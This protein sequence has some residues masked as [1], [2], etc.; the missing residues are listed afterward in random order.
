VPVDRSE[1]L[2]GLPKIDDV[3]RWPEVERLDAPRWA[4]V[5]AA[6]KAVDDRRRAILAGEG[7]PPEVTAAHIGRIAA[8]LARPSLRAVVN[9]TGVVLHTNLGRAPLAGEV[10]ARVAEIAAGYSNLEYDVDGRARGSRHAH[11]RELLRELTGAEDAVVVNNNAG[12]VLLALSALATGRE[13]VVSR[14]ELIEIGGSFRIPDVMRLSGA[15]LV[16]VGTTNKTHARDYEAAIGPDTALLLKVHRSNFAIVGFTDEVGLDE[17]VALA[18]RRG[19]G[20]A[21][22]LGSGALLEAGEL[23][24]AG[25]PPEPSARAGVASGVDL[26]TF[27]GDKLLGGPQAGVLVGGRDAVEA[28]RKHPLMRALRPDKLTLA[29]LE[30]TLAIYRDGRAARDVPSV[31]MLTANAGALRR[32]AEELRR[33]VDAAGGAAAWLALGCASVS[34]PS[35]AARCR[36]PRRRRGRSRSSRATRG[37]PGATSTRSIASCAR[38][39]FRWWGASRRTGCCWTCAPLATW[40]STWWPTRSRGCRRAR[41]RARARARARARGLRSGA[42]VAS[43]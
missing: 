37:D 24:A 8:A 36:R 16:E 31:A 25:L 33:R 35:A 30:A 22:D 29:A 11:L 7:A 20:A 10:I 28:V 41:G 3:L 34:P 17:L 6:R 43:P 39:P 4:V 5:A 14:G 13:V 19:V 27:S 9:A 32:R 40:R 1:L 38:L 2:R 12:A 26:A 18:R 23:A 15:R 42:I 21:I